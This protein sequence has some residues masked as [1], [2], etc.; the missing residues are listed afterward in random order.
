MKLFENDVRC[1]VCRITLLLVE[2]RE[3]MKIKLRD[4]NFNFDY[5]DIVL[6]CHCNDCKVEFFQ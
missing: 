3:T 2:D 1:P 5:D 6:R 4:D